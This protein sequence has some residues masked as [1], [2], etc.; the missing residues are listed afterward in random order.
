MEEYESKNFDH[1]GIVSIICDEIG[2]QQKVDQLMP[3]DSQMSISWGECLKLMVLN[4]LGFTS[5]PLYLEAQFFESRP[6]ARLLG[7]DCL[8]A[9]N[10]DV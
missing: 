7:R 1:L 10:D 4:G 9:I 2:L 3:P 6:V 5:R 8:T